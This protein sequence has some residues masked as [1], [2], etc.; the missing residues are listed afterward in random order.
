MENFFHGVGNMFPF[1]RWYV[2]ILTLQD[3]QQ[4]D[5]QSD[6]QRLKKNILHEPETHF[7]M[8]KKQRPYT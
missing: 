5:F 6:F 4:C 1:Q 8:L 7:H 2:F 3:F